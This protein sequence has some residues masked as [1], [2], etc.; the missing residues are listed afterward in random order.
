MLGTNE[1]G[2]RIMCDQACCATCR[3]CNVWPGVKCNPALG[4]GMIKFPTER[5]V[6][7]R[8]LFWDH[9]SDQGSCIL[10]HDDEHDEWT[11]Y[12]AGLPV[13][14]P[15]DVIPTPD[16]QDDHP[17]SGSDSSLRK[18]DDANPGRG[19]DNSRLGTDEPGKG[20]PGRALSKFD[21]PLAADSDTPIEV[22]DDAIEID[23]A[24]LATFGGGV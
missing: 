8:L 17:G 2:V 16:A 3:P 21:R 1:T 6:S 5:S 4:H 20:L 7:G 15:P 19:I 23:H 12:R 24:D 18:I 14:A 9:L 11:V 22:D 13:L 10:C